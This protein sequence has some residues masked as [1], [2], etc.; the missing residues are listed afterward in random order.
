M[1]CSEEQQL[2]LAQQAD[3]AEAAATAV[4][5]LSL[6]VRV[7]AASADCAVCG[8]TVSTLDGIK[9]PSG[10]HFVCNECFDGWAGSECTP[11]DEAVPKDAGN[12]WCPM[13]PGPGGPGCSSI[14][15]FDVKVRT[16]SYPMAQ[17]A[18]AC[19]SANV[20]CVGGFACLM[21]SCASQTALATP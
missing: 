14:R 2:Q 17:L 3:Q 15:P 4:A 10:Q 1:L 5:S 13:K 9:C 16:T 19:S 6:Q 18:C 12:V 11:A 7:S 20:I 21:L 8:E